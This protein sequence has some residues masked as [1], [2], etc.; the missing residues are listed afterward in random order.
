MFEE[1]VEDD[2]AN[3]KNTFGD[4]KRFGVFIILFAYADLLRISNLKWQI[5]SVRYKRYMPIYP[6]QT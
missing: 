5:N 2:L 1:D 4:W 6:V 3:K